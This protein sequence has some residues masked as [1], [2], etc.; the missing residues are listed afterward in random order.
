MQS[1]KIR[2][3]AL[4]KRVKIWYN[5]SIIK[6]SYMFETGIALSIF[7]IGLGVIDISLSNVSLAGEI[8]APLCLMVGFAFSM[9]GAILKWTK[10]N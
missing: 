3:I 1:K 9:A 10:E 2:K 5:S 6:E 8:I 7:A 4:D